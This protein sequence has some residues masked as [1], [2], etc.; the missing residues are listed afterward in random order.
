[1]AC[2][3]KVMVPSLAAILLTGGCVHGSTRTAPAMLPARSLTCDLGHA[4]NVDTSRQ[5]SDDELVFDARHQLGLFLPAIPVRTSE[6]PDPAYPVSEPVNKHTRI[7]RDPDKITADIIAPFNRV[8]DY[9]PDRVEMTAPI[10]LKKYKLLIVSGYDANTHRAKLFMTNA[11]D[12]STWDMGKIFA[13]YCD[14]VIST[15]RQ[16][17]GR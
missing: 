8:V 9:W 10:G 13:G 5:Q 3:F 17:R 12:L 1:M 7:T 2:A 16:G 15:A 11:V 14:V 6:P 4:T